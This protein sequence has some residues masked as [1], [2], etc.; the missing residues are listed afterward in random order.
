MIYLSINDDSFYF[1]DS[2]VSKIEENDILVEKEIHDKFIE[3]TEKA[4]KFKVINPKGNKF[5]EIFEEI[6]QEIINLGEIEP[7]PIEKLQQE[8]V[9]LRKQIESTQQGMAEIMNLIAIQ[10]I[11]PIG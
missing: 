8:N 4:K 7:N 3:E 9:E 2:E 6:E 5:Y 11:T 10:G 1:K